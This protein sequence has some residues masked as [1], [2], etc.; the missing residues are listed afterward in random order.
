MGRRVLCYRILGKQGRFTSAPSP[1][2]ETQLA[3]SSDMGR[4]PLRRSEPS[5][6]E[7]ETDKETEGPI[8]LG[9]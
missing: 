5:G 9:P 3:W 7:G 8:P 6:G 4:L 1:F 2:P